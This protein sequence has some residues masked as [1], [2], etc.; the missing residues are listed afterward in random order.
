MRGRARPVVLTDVRAARTGTLTLTTA[1]DAQRQ[2]LWWL[3]E[4][5]HTLLAQWPA[6][7]GIGD[8]YLQVGDAE[9]NRISDYAPQPDREFVLAVTE[10]DRPVGALVGSAGR[11]WQS[12]LDT[13][14]TWA[15]VLAR[16]RTWLDVLT[17]V[18]GS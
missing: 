8:L 1:T 4:S 14:T 11:T 12:V 16:S 3:L 9:E 2:A 5:G 13:N 6:S 17:G 18:Q 10:V 15:D 7:W